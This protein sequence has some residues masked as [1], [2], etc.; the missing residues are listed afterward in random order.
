MKIF[1]RGSLNIIVHLLHSFECRVLENTVLDILS[2][3]L[4]L[5]LLSFQINE[6]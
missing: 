5:F 6:I 4:S 1:V 3:A 2:A